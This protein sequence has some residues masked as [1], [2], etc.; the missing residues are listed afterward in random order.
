[1][2]EG[3]IEVLFV[4]R[5]SGAVKGSDDIVSINSNEK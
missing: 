3:V 2:E 4:D 5:L 1:V